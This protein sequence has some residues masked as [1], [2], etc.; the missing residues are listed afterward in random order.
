MMSKA[1]NPSD[2]PKKAARKIAELSPLRPKLAI[3]LG[4]GFHGVVERMDVQARISYKRFP[5]FPRPSVSGHA[6]ELLI[7]NMSGIPILI[8]SGRAHYYEGHDMSVVTFAVRTLATYGI[9]DLVLT[10]AAGGV[11]RKFRPGD[12]M[13]LSDHINLMGTNP[14]RGPGVPGLPRF[15]DQTQV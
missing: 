9:R 2:D 1:R 15:V 5:G 11:N 14:L 12:F 8:L 3:V 13:L 10:N 6:G 7:G 4:S